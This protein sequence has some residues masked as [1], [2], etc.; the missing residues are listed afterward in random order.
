MSVNDDR[1]IRY[2]GDVQ[3]LTFNEGDTL[4]L[5]LDQPISEELV[6][7]LR[8]Q[9]QEILGKDRKYLILGEG[10]KIGVLAA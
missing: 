2:L 1:E 9:L 5:T 4:V 7:R 3:R 6:L 10:M 8:E